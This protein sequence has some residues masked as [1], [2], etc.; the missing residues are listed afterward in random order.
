MAKDRTTYEPEYEEEYEEEYQEEVETPKRGKSSSEKKSPLPGI[1]LMAL[2]TGALIFVAMIYIERKATEGVET[3]SVYR[4][5][6]AVEKGTRID[7]GNFAVYFEIAQVDVSLEPENKLSGIEDIQEMYAVT[8]ISKGS[9]VTTSMFLESDVITQQF[10]DPVL[11]GFTVAD[12]VDSVNGVIRDGDYVDIYLKVPYQIKKEFQIPNAEDPKQEK[13]VSFDYEGYA[14]ELIWENVFIQEAFDGDLATEQGETKIHSSQ[15]NIYLPRSEAKAFLEAASSGS[16]ILT[17][18][19]GD[20]YGPQG[21]V[22][23]LDDL[24]MYIEQIKEK[25]IQ[26]AFEEAVNDQYRTVNPEEDEVLDMDSEAEE[27]IVEI[28][29]DTP[30]EDT[31]LEPVEVNIQD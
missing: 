14:E 25:Q 26:D 16:I 5:K 27:D 6:S 18:R 11:I 30:E 12:T 20:N 29:G 31:E 28:S 4:A 17:K 8:D 15:Y 1:I 10:E 7:E 19:I 2:L 23:S 22:V 9:I 24:N 21:I 3:V 13:R